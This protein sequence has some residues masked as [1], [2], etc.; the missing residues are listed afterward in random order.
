MVGETSVPD[1]NLLVFLV[2]YTL[3]GVV[4][5]VLGMLVDLLIFFISF[6][7]DQLLAQ[8]QQQLTVIGVYQSEIIIL[9]IKK[10]P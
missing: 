4:F 7:P 8:H 9:Y 5:V 6:E 1:V 10:T 2:F 3:E